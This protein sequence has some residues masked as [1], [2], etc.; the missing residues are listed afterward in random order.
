[1]LKHLL[2]IFFVSMLAA[3]CAKPPVAD[4]ED[5]RSVVAHAYASGA[6]R[7]A[8]GEYQLASSALLAAEQQVEDGKSRQALNT[9]ALARRYASES[10]NITLEY[11]KKLA[12]EQQRQA[13]EKRTEELRK[14]LQRKRELELE[15]QRRAELEKQRLLELKRAAAL[16]AE[17]ARKKAAEEAARKKAVKKPVKPRLV[18]KVE[19]R[20]GEN[21]ADIAARPDVYND[22]MLWP[23]I[24][25]ANRDQIKDPQEVFAGQVFVVPRDKSRAEIDAARREAKSLKLF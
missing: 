12:Q 11:K 8:P 25:K 19:V 16:E 6:A 21:L 18:D 23:L 13:E 15:Q 10:L 20:P 17:T 1:M 3:G 24:Y 2:T 5:V 7:Y 4:L 22:T 9:L 14:E